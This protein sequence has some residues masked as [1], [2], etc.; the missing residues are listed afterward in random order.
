MGLLALG[1]AHAAEDFSKLSNK[2]FVLKAGTMH[3]AEDVIQYRLEV[4]KRVKAMKSPKAKAEFKHQVKKAEKANFAKMSAADFDKLREEVAEE[5]SKMKQEH[6]PQ[7]LKAM[8]LANVEVCKGEEHKMWCHPKH[9]K[10]GE[11]HKG[12]H[13]AH[14]KEHKGEHKEH[15]EHGSKAEHAPAKAEHA[16]HAEHPAGAKPAATH[17]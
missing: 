2:Q 15:E 4:A 12:E 6:K 10:K 1:V 17:E 9:A 13:H 14:K 3:D 7:E 8:G 16:E 11:H 5:L